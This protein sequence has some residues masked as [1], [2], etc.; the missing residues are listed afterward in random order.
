MNFNQGT[1]DHWKRRTLP[2][3]TF[4]ELS[5]YDFRFLRYHHAKKMVIF[6]LSPFLLLTRCPSLAPCLTDLSQTLRQATNAKKLVFR[7]KNIGHRVVIYNFKTVLNA[8]VIHTLNLY[9]SAT[10]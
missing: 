1:N 7:G 8:R 2:F 6:N 4:F 10:D 3:K 5:R 9:T